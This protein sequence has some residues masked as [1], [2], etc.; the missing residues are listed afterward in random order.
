LVIRIAPIVLALAICGTISVVIYRSVFGEN[1][2]TAFAYRV[3]IVL[4]AITVAF[5]LATVF[6]RGWIAR[7]SRKDRR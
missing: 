1:S 6:M 3:N 4:W 2:V 7:W 5:G